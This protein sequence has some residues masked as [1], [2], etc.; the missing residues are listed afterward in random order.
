MDRHCEKL[1]LQVDK[2]QIN[3][4][5]TTLESYD[6]MALVRTLDA[7]AGLVQVHIAPGCRE[8]LLSVLKSLVQEGLSI[9]LTNMAKY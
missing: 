8:L 9:S 1:V 4:I 6:G 3:Y 7:R 2:E 5:R